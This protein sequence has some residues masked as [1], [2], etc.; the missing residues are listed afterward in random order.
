MT[1]STP[2]NAPD[3]TEIVV[4][5]AATTGAAA[6]VRRAIATLARYTHEPIT[7]A[8]V[9]L[10]RRPDPAATR[11]VIA[12]ANVH[13][14]RQ[15]IRVQVAARTT[16]EAIDLLQARLQDRLLR[17]VRHA[18]ARRGSRS[19]HRP[20]YLPRRAQER[21]L[22]RRKTYGSA[23]ATPEDA[24]LDMDLLDYDF[25]LFTDSETGQDAVVYRAGP[26]GYRLAELT[27]PTASWP[28]RAV[29]L[30]VSGQPAARLSQAAAI[31]RLNLTNAPFLFFADVDTGRGQVLYRRYDGHYGLLAPAGEHPRHAQQPQGKSGPVRMG[32]S[33]RPTEPPAR[34]DGDRGD[35]Q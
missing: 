13:L 14:G 28:C 17:S 19:R 16:R 7:H 26:T 18:Q 24:A 11:P 29:P 5:G 1:L 15:L 22:R 21:E 23:Y 9:R 25:Y 8:R 30:T 10:I 34:H 4:Q 33:T 12:Q 31:E 32:P 35:Q 3:T 27:P 2:A 20:E 6:A